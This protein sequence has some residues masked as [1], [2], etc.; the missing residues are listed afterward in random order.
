MNELKNRKMPT[1]YISPIWS[2]VD[3]KVTS[4][5]EAIK[6]LSKSWI[7]GFTEAEGSFYLT[8]KEAFRIAHAFEITQK[9]D[10]ILLISLAY[11]FNMK[12]LNKKS[13]LLVTIPK[14]KTICVI[15]KLLYH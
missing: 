9:L 3:Y 12:F 10:P 13:N 14:L 2:K 5:E 1:N 7:V 15:S 11:I 4:L 8:T 6:V